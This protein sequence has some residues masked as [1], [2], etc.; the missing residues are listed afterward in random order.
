VERE[1]EDG[2]DTTATPGSELANLLLLLCHEHECEREYRVNAH[3]DNASLIA[4]ASVQRFTSSSARERQLAT[5]L[6]IVDVDYT[7]NSNR[8]NPLQVRG[9]TS[10][11]TSKVSGPLAILQ[12]ACA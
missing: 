12:A 6:C 1:C 10:N 7:V 3:G 9:V 2:R 8:G 5:L 11:A 4:S